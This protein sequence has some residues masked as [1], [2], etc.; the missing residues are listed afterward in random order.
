M[1]PKQGTTGRQG[2]KEAGRQASAYLE[3]RDELHE[4]L[5]TQIHDLGDV[6]RAIS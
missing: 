3:V 6:A 5:K 4:D 1:G 2:G